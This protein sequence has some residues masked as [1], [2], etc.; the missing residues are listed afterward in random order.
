MILADIA[1]GRRDAG[2]AGDLG[3]DNVSDLILYAHV[4]R[5]GG[6]AAAARALGIPKSRL[7]RRV[8]RLEA[9]L[10]VRLL[11]R[12]SRGFAVT[13][14]GRAL[15][16]QCETIIADVEAAEATVAATLAEPQ[17]LVRVSCPTTLS[18]FWLGPALPRFL[19]RHP[20]I[21]VLLE[22]VNH[23]VDLI[24]EHF[25]VAIRVRHAL[26]EEPNLIIRRLFETREIL[27]ANVR[28]L[29][30]AAGLSGPC[31]LRNLPTLAL[32]PPGI[33]ARWTLVSPGGASVT[34]EHR[35]RLL[36][37]DMA[38]IREAAI[39]G[40]GVALLPELVC[41]EALRSGRLTAILPAWERSPGTVQ[42]AFLERRG[43]AP[44]VRAFVDFLAELPPAGSGVA[45]DGGR[46]EGPC[47]V[48]PSG[49]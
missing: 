18:Q 45:S 3:L 28:R 27:V 37:D 35:P 41:A 33:V 1:G 44:A 23:R 7:S 5:R 25:D 39:A 11:D 13:E 30:A 12:N 6:F 48:I 19:A 38:A 2:A 17:G 14:V 32:R 22:P 9:R 21:T 8:A 10:G 36:T 42:A 20:R 49:S 46:G 47:P 29:P 4:V 31:E 24:A 26:V 43:M 40:L 34:L 16:V 15:H